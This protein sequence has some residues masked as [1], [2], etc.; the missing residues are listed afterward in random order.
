[1]ANSPSMQNSIQTARSITEE[2]RI[3]SLAVEMGLLAGE[4][5]IECIHSWTQQR[6]QSF[7]E[8]LIAN[9]G[10]ESDDVSLVEALLDERRKSGSTARP[11][12]ETDGPAELDI[13]FQSDQ[14]GNWTE[15]FQTDRFLARGGL[16]VVFQGHD[17]ELDRTVA[18]KELDAEYAKDPWAAERFHRESALTA[19]LEHPSI[20]PIYGRGVRPDGTP[21]Y[22]MRMIAGRTLREVADQV[23]QAKKQGI[24]TD[25]MEFRKLIGQLIPVSQAIEAVE[26]NRRRAWRDDAD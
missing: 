23:H 2:I 14:P 6:S 25:R 16:G 5:L 15:R 7:L 18:I 12:Q 24:A 9:S 3:G 20:V 4:S 1:M 22:A 8:I 26:R 11:S 13:F 21:F 19:S 10:L 17:R